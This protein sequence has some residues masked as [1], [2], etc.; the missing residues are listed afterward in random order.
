[1]FDPLQC[2]R[3]KDRKDKMMMIPSMLIT[4]GGSH[5]TSVLG[6][7]VPGD[8]SQIVLGRTIFVLESAEQLHL[9]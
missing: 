5:V 7:S 2:L 8:L 1:M 9:V 3:K 4:L 6:T